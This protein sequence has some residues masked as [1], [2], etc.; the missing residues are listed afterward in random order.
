M[1][2]IGHTLLRLCDND[3]TIELSKLEGLYSGLSLRRAKTI[4]LMIG[5]K[6]KGKS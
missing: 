5:V 1:S 3:L 2:P 4:A 6:I